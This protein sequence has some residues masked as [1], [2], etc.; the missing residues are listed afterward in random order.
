MS[1]WSHN[2]LIHRKEDI[3]GPSDHR[4]HRLRNSR[5][6][7][8]GKMFNW[9]FGGPYTSGIIESGVLDSE[10]MDQTTKV[11]QTISWGEELVLDTHIDELK[12]ENTLLKR[13]IEILVEDPEYVSGLEQELRAL[14]ECLMKSESELFD[15]R[16]SGD[17]S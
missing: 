5:R 11:A 16:R 10:G 13:T 17:G 15:L 4:N 7:G 6:E 12:E 1:Y 9:L 3:E 14:K 8:V 2:H